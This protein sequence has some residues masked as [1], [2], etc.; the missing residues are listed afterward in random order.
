MI[1]DKET[2]I[3]YNEWKSPAPEAVFL[4]VHGLGA[5]TGRWEFLAGFFLQNRISS[6]AIEL[7]G[8]G[9]TEDLKGHID[10]FNTYLRDIK[11]LY[12]IIVRENKNKKVFLVGESV[13]AVISFLAA[14]AEPDLFD[15]LICISPAFASSLKATPLTYIKTLLPLV[16]NPR[17]QFNIPFDSRMCT[18]DTDY[19]KVMDAD[20]REHRLATSKFI[21]KLMIAQARCNFSKNKV[22]IPALFLLSG[23][24]KLVDPEAGKRIFKGLKAE[25]KTIIQYP[26]MYHALSI[27]LGREKVFGDILKWVRERM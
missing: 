2:G 26:D 15:G 22:K 5:H 16:Y 20:S 6:Y 8:F 11:S 4:L 3:I 13:G 23:E 12:D 10:S 24:D 18:R 1:R 7:K 21:F 27:D 9:E 25:D 14:I 19:Q 17:K